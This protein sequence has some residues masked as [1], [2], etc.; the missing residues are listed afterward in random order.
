M[1]GRHEK[2]AG[3]HALQKK[4]RQNTVV[5]MCFSGLRVN[6]EVSALKAKYAVCFVGYIVNVLIPL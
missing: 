3:R 4:P 5:G 6:S 1:A 2:R